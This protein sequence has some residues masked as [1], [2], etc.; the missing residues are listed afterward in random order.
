MRRALV[1]LL[2]AALA[3]PA[4]AAAQTTAPGQAPGTEPQETPGPPDLVLSG[5]NIRLT[6]AGVLGVKLGCRTS[7]VA[8]EA[9]IGSLTVR[10][11]GTI[12]ITAP[13][14]GRPGGRPVKQT[15]RPFN[16]GVIDFTI[17]EGDSAEVRVRV[18]RRA[19]DLIR[20]QE[21]VRVDLI[22]NYNDRAGQAGGSRRNVRVYFPTRPGS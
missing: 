1:P 4:A 14:L 18:N 21:R 17:V 6:R 11:A 19:S 10:L 2:A 16:F 15:I 12:T 13:P 8:N 5:R 22:A 9:C 3:W 7:P 20:R